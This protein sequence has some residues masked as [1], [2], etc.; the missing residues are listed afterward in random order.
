MCTRN[1]T[2]LVQNV[3]HVC[4][5]WW[6]LNSHRRQSCE[7]EFK[8]EHCDFTSR[9]I[10]DMK[11]HKLSDAPNFIIWKSLQDGT[12]YLTDGPFESYLVE[13]LLNFSSRHFCY[14]DSWTGTGIS[15]RKKGHVQMGDSLFSVS[16]NH[17]C[18]GIFV[19]DEAMKAWHRRWN[20]KHETSNMK[21]R[22]WN[23]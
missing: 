8:C 2:L 17:F 12:L 20:M 13:I 23:I 18:C 9:S 3:I 5:F 7:N 19:Q 16:F 14:E 15:K 10:E 6:P 1:R 21:H 4:C 11:S 22:T